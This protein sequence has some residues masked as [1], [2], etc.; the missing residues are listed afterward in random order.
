M[1]SSKKQGVGGACR[2]HGGLLCARL[3]SVLRVVRS[4]PRGHTASE[5]GGQ[6]SDAVGSCKAWTLS[7]PLL[8][9]DRMG[10]GVRDSQA[11]GGIVPHCKVEQ[12][13]YYYCLC[14]CGG[15]S[16]PSGEKAP[17]LPTPESAI[18]FYKTCGER[19]SGDILA[20]HCHRA[21]GKEK[22]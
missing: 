3:R 12:S 19:V 16:K 22:Q 7:P 17:A 21:K 15:E 14:V 20:V 18:K 8:G 1:A 4:L 11:L 6:A 2:K 13:D 9:F 5:W 10:P